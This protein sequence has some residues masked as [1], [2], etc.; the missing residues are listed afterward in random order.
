MRWFV[1]RC[2]ECDEISEFGVDADNPVF[3]SECRSVDSME[4]IEDDSEPGEV[5]EFR[6]RGE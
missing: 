2:G 4:V 6:R 5:L 3:C 1:G